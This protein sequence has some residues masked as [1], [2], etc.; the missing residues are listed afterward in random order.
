MT[1]AG[2]PRTLAE[3]LTAAGVVLTPI[4]PDSVGAPEVSVPIPD[5]WLPLE[6]SLVPGAYRVWAQPPADTVPWAD[7]AVLLVGGLSARVDWS[8]IAG[9]AFTDSR[10]LPGWVDI[11]TDSDPYRGFPSAAITGAYTVDE[12]TLWAHTRY[13]LCEFGATQYLVQLTVTVRA[14]RANAAV[15]EICDGLTITDPAAESYRPFELS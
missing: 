9:S 3:Q 14:E 11:R 8:S 13:V 6:P 12:L 7:N 5:K 4:H 15:Q 1:T 2:S 10:K